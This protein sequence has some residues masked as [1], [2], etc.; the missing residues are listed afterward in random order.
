MSTYNGNDVYIKIDS[1]EVDAYFKTIEFNPSIETVDVT[2]GSGTDHRQRAG[3]LEDTTITMTIVYDAANI[4]AYIQRLKP[5]VHSIEFGPE[6]NTSGK[7]RHVQS[8]IITAAP[9]SV[10]VSKTEVA[11]SISGEAADAPS[12]D[13]MAGQV[14]S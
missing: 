4:Q 14:Y 8:F 10:E 1:V 11:F 9:F 7:P 6:G 13:M 5:G 2:A 12:V 3:G